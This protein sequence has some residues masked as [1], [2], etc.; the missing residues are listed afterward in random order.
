[1]KIANMVRS[2][3]MMSMDFND[4]DWARVRKTLERDKRIQ[5]VA[6]STLGM[7]AAYEAVISGTGDPKGLDM[8]ADATL[9]AFPIQVTVTDDEAHAYVDHLT[10]NASAQKAKYEGWM[11][12]AY[13]DAKYERVYKA[14]IDRIFDQAG[15]AGQQKS[16]GQMQ[17]DTRTQYNADLAKC[18][19]GED[20]G[21]GTM[22]GPAKCK[23]A[24]A[25]GAAGGGGG[26]GGLGA[27]GSLVGLGGGGASDAKAASSPNGADRAM[28]G[29]G[30]AQAAANGDVS[31]ALDGATSAFPG[32]GPIQS[33]LKGI[34]ALTKGDPKGAIAAAMN[35]VPGGSLVKEG[36]GAVAKLFGFG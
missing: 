22:V 19:R 23:E 26:G 2:R 10:D 7:L 4:D 14:G 27:L 15:S 28:A 36:L 29:A 33:S 6:A 16:I 20:P 24:R 17:A 35:L 32:D 1:M 18:A 9:K 30:A 34:S 25:N 21:P 12:Q 8:L 11:R 13:G 3:K 5:T 31:G